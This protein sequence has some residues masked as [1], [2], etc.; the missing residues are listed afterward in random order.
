M[1]GTNEAGT[2][3]PWS[4]EVLCVPRLTWVRQPGEGFVVLHSS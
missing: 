4:K 3:R 1:R 2:L